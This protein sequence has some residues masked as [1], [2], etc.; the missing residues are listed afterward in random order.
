MIN[1]EN[2]YLSNEGMPNR[3]AL[4]LGAQKILHV[5]CRIGNSEEVIYVLH[6]TSRIWLAKVPYNFLRTWVGCGHSSRQSRYCGGHPRGREARG[7]PHPSL[8][9]DT[10]LAPV[11]RRAGAHAWAGAVR[12][13]WRKRGAV[14]WLV[15]V[16]SI[17][18]MVQCVLIGWRIINFRR[19]DLPGPPWREDKWGSTTTVKGLVRML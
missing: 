11:A 7:C 15:G 9:V 14:S 8:R 2:P 12:W 4:P 1:S 17:L 10:L 19:H 13:R 18:R 6:F 16:V 5:S 3:C